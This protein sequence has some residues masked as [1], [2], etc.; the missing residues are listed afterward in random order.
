MTASDVATIDTNLRAAIA[1][2]SWTSAVNLALQLKA[3][4]AALSDAGKGSLNIRWKS[5]RE[6]DSLIADL[7]VEE[8]SD[9]QGEGMSMQ[10]TKLDLISPED[11]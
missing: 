9:P 6:L 10:F 7:R 5:P 8:A 2:S 1:G 4:L 11:C 3:G